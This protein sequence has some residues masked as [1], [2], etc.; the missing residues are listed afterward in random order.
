MQLT[1]KRQINRVNAF[2]QKAKTVKAKSNRHL[3]GQTE[4]KKGKLKGHT[5]TQQGIQEKL[6]TFFSRFMRM[7]E[8]MMRRSTDE[9]TLPV[10]LQIV[11]NPLFKSI[12]VLGVNSE[13][14]TFLCSDHLKLVPVDRSMGGGCV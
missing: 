12:I 11:T 10:L 4:C 6:D 1:Q 14:D 2:R 8:V 5:E 7:G 13:N 9:N 3:A